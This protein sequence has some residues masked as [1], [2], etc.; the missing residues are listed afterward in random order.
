MPLAYVAR[1]AGTTYRVV[2]LVRQAGNRFLSSLKGLQIRALAGRY[3][4]PIPTRF[5]A[6]IYC[7]KIP[8]LYVK[9]RLASTWFPNCRPRAKSAVSELHIFYLCIFF[10]F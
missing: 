3:D 7:L 9:C 6:P 4:H 8:A 1:R 5:L 10:T 2:V